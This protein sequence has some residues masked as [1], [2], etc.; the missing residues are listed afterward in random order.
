MISEPGLARG[1]GSTHL[2]AIYSPFVDLKVHR[3]LYLNLNIYF[4][5][6]SASERG[7]AQKRFMLKIDI[8][9]VELLH[10]FWIRY[11]GNSQNEVI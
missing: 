7:S 4:R 5:G 1:L 9:I 6:S 10:L 3:G 11:S 2:F 8:D